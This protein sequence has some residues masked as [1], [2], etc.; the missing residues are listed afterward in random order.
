[1]PTFA[2]T[3]DPG[4]TAAVTVVGDQVNYEFS[5]KAWDNYTG[6]GGSGTSSVTDLYA[7]K[8]IGFDLVLAVKSTDTFGMLC[9]NTADS[10]AYNPTQFAQLVC[11]SGDWANYWPADLSQDNQ[12]DLADLARLAAK[13]M[14]CSDPRDPACE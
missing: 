12:V 13:W 7:G 14:T 8:I 5:V 3:P 4:L 2:A 10:K 9:A 6:K 11:T 1:M